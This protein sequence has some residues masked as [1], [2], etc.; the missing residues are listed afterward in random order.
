MTQSPPTAETTHRLAKLLVDAGEATS[1]QEAEKRLQSLR[2]SI[3]IGRDVARS[4][5][6]QAALLTAVNVA[7]RAFIG[8]VHVTGDLS[9][10]CSLPGFLGQSLRECVEKN[11]GTCGEDRDPT[12]PLLV[13]GESSDPIERSR[14]GLRITFQGW[15]GGVTPLARR[16]RLN[17][18]S[19]CP[20]S[21]ILG[22]AVAVS[23]A[24]RATRGEAIAGRINVG[25]SLWRPESVIDWMTPNADEGPMSFL[26]SKLWLIGLGNLG[27]AF[28]W[29]LGC[30]PYED[31]HAV[32]LVLQDYDVLSQANVSTSILTHAHH[33]GL[34]KT[35][36]MSAWAERL[37]FQTCLN[38]RRFNS[39]FHI[40]ANEPQLA[41]CGV[42][43]AVARAAVEDV[44]FKRIV[45]AGL[46]AGVKDFTA[47]L[48]HTFPG[49]ISA[50]ER[51]GGVSPPLGDQDVLNKPGY[52]ALSD[53][54]ID[55]CG[56]AMLASRTVGAPFVGVIAACLALA[57][58]LRMMNGGA[59]YEVIEANLVALSE[60][61]AV[62]KKQVV[63]PF[64]PGI[65]K[66]YAID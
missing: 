18:K 23:E 45:E 43:N 47:L 28:L 4:Y 26:P 56:I 34:K 1:F 32:E 12:I 54:G 44:G 61:T 37:G 41:F 11:G 6:H 31:A 10:G 5:N 25:L 59:S 27:Q 57:E 55:E 9:T 13:I 16:V 8:G 60:R 62:R 3:T 51:W 2:I 48:I 21:A 38:E 53:E 33:I 17:E 58:I 40:E 65:A 22:A 52:A 7:S 20:L 24:F 29:S 30:L 15:S 66:A 64:N 42:D 39:D 63:E 49:S 14:F 50:R 46:G 19:S 35:R 36:A